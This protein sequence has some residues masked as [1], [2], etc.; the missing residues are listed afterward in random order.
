MAAVVAHADW[1]VAPGKR[2]CC[3]ARLNPSGSQY[4]VSVPRP[5]GNV[6]DFFQRL[7]D[8]SPDGSVL[9]GFDF[10]LGLPMAYARQTDVNDFKTFLAGLG[11]GCWSN[12]YEV[13]TNATEI[14]LHRPFYPARPGGTRHARLCTAL[15]VDDIDALRRR[16][17]RKTLVRAAASPLFWT[18]GGQQVG[19][20]AIAGWRDLLQPALQQSALDVRLWPFE[21]DL[22]ALRAAQRIVVAETYPAESGLHLGLPASGRGWSKRKQPDRAAHADALLTWAGSRGV[23]VCDDLARQI[24][25]GFGSA[26]DGEDRFDAMIGTLGMLEVVL[27]HRSDMPALDDETRRIEGWIFGQA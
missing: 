3:I 20:A 18:L 26:A 11:Q 22:A 12:F 21:G 9:A 27:G 2:W 7:S 1:S 8:L 14:R 16:C 19:R 24:H 23:T 17:E 5:A 10:P 6:A 15:G 13:C 25:S 4:T